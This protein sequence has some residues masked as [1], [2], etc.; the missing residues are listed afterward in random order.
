MEETMRRKKAKTTIYDIGRLPV[1]TEVKKEPNYQTRAEFYKEQELIAAREQKAAE[2]KLLAPVRE[3]EEQVKQALAENSQKVKR[4]YSQSIVD[5]ED[6]VRYGDALPD[7]R[8]LPT[9]DQ[10]ISPVEFNGLV[11]KFVDTL[12]S[13]GMNIPP[14]AVRRFALYSWTQYKNGAVINSDTLDVLFERCLALDIFGGEVTG[15]LV[16]PVQQAT[17]PEKPS[18]DE[19]LKTTSGD[20]RAGKKLLEQAVQ[21][22]AFAEATPLWVEFLQHLLSVFDFSP[23][24]A[25]RKYILDELFPR[26]NWSYNSPKAYLA[27]KRHM[28]S[29]HRWPAS[30][31]TADEQ[32]AREVEDAPLNDYH[33]RRELVRR[34]KDS[35]G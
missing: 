17:G 12:E 20:T 5:L 30:L 2:E 3:V 34:V 15:E 8:G 19:L 24:G 13:R 9:T 18:L 22:A 31:L 25:D 1:V 29:I 28:V 35:R 10:P 16:K 6:A 7:P 26:N 32:L 27:A 23:S 33:Q 4:C 21:D 14:D 11:Q